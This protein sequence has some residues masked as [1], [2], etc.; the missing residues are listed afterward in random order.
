MNFV[1]WVTLLTLLVIG[2]AG[3]YTG[4]ASLVSRRPGQ[5]TTLATDHRERLLFALLYL[6]GGAVALLAAILW[7]ASRS[8]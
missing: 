6:S 1:E 4:V 5:K 3:L 2:A 7:M 8:R